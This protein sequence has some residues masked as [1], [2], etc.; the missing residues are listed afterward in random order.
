M[1]DVRDPFE[2]PEPDVIDVLRAA[3]IFRNMPREVLVEVAARLERIDVP[4][5]QT[6]FE[7]GDP[8]TAMYI[9]EDG[10]VRV[11]DDEMTINYL[12]T[13]DVFGEMAA[14][15]S[16]PRSAS[17]TAVKDTVLYRL[18]QAAFRGVIATSP[19]VGLAVVRVLSGHLRG[20]VAEMREDFDYMQQFAAVTAAA[21]A[22][23]AGAY[24]PQSL[25][26]VAQ[27][28]DELGQLA[29]VFQR[30]AREVYTREQR[31]KAEIVALQ[32]EVDEAKKSREVAEITDTAYFQELATLAKELRKA[33]R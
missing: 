18:D 3:S 10:N 6:V 5:G 7:K 17:V 23:E 29:R 26:E 19:E 21:V 25:N 15:D 22:L 28:S 24:D 2:L 11:H 14:I 12:G 31:L 4:A 13:R 33:R 16:Q 8:G 27:R 30:M 9:I 32:I 20:N 1:S